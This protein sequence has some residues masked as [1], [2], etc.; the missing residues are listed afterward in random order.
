MSAPDNMPAT[1][2]EAVARLRADGQRSYA[3]ADAFV[4][5]LPD[6]QRARMGRMVTVEPTDADDLHI[7]CG[8]R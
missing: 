7:G 5:S 8:C 4:A 6:D 3:A 2:E 1:R